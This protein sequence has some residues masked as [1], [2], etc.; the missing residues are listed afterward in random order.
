MSSQNPPPGAGGTPDPYGQPGFG[1]DNSGAPWQQP[2]GSPQQ[3][4]TGPHGPGPQ[5]AGPY[6]PGPTGPIQGPPFQAQ[7]GPGQYDPRYAAHH[8]SAPVS[9]H[10]GAGP[11][12]AMPSEPR[13]GRG[14]R[15]GLLIGLLAGGVV[16]VGGG[17][18]AWMAFFNQGPQPAEALPDDTLAYLSVD[19]DPSG[20]QKIEAL[21]T[22]RKFPAFKEGTGLEADD[23]VRKKIFESI[24][25]SGA[26]TELDYDDDIEPW[27]GDRAAVAV[28]D[29]GNEHPD[30][31]LVV[32]VKNQDKAEDGLNKIV[33][34]GND[35][36]GES[37][38]IGGYAFNGDW[39]V[40][41]ETEDIAQT[42]VDDA[43][44]ASLQDD[45]QY[46]KWTDAAGD[47]GVISVYASS[48]AGDQ[49]AEFSPLTDAVDSE[50]GGDSDELVSALEDFKGG[51]GTVRFND[52]NLEIE[53]ATGQMNTASSKLISGDRGDDTLSTLPDST[54]VALGAGMADGWGEALFEQLRPIIEDQTMES[55]DEAIAD[56]EAE[57]GL[58]LPEDLE[59]LFGESFVLALDSN[60]DPDQVVEGGP[61]ELPVA[62]KVKGDPDEIEAT[63]DKMRARMSEDLGS[64]V[65]LL[66][67][68]E[69]DGYVLV[70]PSQAYL[71]LLADG[72]DLGGDD[73]FQSVVPEAED[74][75]AILFANFDAGDWLLEVLR[76]AEAPAEVLDNAEPLEA[77]GISSWTDGDEVH[78]L[79]KITTE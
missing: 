68:E 29:Q 60:F 46:Q 28:I 5:G 53:F 63:L 48:E 7:G 78:A 23:D 44:D 64:D 66:T 51:A 38:D 36:T 39:V 17:V 9:E 74:S 32:Q 11:G 72:G 27:L 26:C 56:A 37:E 71:D 3:G 59:T 58:S 30:P 41:A 1:Q 20:E 43:K 6:D 52:G 55:F 69:H 24:Q 67:S 31:V 33:N 22:L 75:S 65:E 2:G 79:I 77:M 70:S 21:R 73:T 40:L 19:L 47:P 50:V 42:V 10:L 34:C 13:S 35:A 18:W 49:L 8:G 45:E 14:G 57:T 54:A 61:T 15:R 16:L 25:D 4:Q 12:G 62:F 76:T